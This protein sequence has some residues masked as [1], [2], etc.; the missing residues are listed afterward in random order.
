[1]VETNLNQIQPIED[2]KEV[3]EVTK[4]AKGKYQ[5]K[6][7]IKPNF[8]DEKELKRLKDIVNELEREYND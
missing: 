8:I 5:F 6:V 7:K 1:M 3:V 2:S 4:N